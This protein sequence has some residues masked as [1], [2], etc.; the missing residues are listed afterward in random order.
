MELIAETDGTRLRY[1]EHTM[2]LDGKDASAGRREGCQAL[3][4]RLASELEAH[5]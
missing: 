2:H 3:F 1:T 5:A 4:E